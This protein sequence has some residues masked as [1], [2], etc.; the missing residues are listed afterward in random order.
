MTAS[1]DTFSKK[2]ARA[3]LKALE[4]SDAKKLLT[5]EKELTELSILSHEPLVNF[6]INP[7]FHLDEKTAVLDEV[8]A[9]AKL[10]EETKQFMLTLLSLNHVH[11]IEEIAKDF[12]FELR[13]MHQE[14]KVEVQTAYPLS[15]EEQEKIRTT[16]EKVLS[17]K[18]L[19]NIT[20]NRDLI[21]GIRAQVG[22]V[23]YDSS[24]QG[25][26]MRLQKEFSL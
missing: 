9:K 22:G 23:V 16:F 26:L 11:M 2:Y 25:H 5:I 8:I 24:V 13:E 20:T 4:G 10:Q 17:R 21:G 12:S 14:T 6:F 18:I 1:I 3:F 19:L 7:V 15:K